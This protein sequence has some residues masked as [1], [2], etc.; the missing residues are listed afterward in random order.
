MCV[1]YFLVF[2]MQTVSS[3]KISKLRFE[4]TCFGSSEIGFPYFFSFN[5]LIKKID[6][7][8]FEP[9]RFHCYK[10]QNHTVLVINLQDA[11]MFGKFT[12]KIWITTIN[13]IIHKGR[14]FLLLISAFG[15]EP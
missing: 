12:Y 4:R 14:I 10:G 6:K 2:M 11:I 3:Y 8:V 1:C 9:R 15:L 13:F 5:I 7:F